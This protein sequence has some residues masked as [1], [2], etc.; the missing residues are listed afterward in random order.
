LTRVANHSDTGSVPIVANLNSSAS[1]LEAASLSTVE[2]FKG[3]P[4]SHLHALEERS[5]VH[6]FRAGHVFFRTG[7]TGQRLFLLEK[8][9]V[10]TF[11]ATGANKL[12]IAELKPPAIFG[13]MAFVGQCM[14]H[15][16]A[17]TTVASRIRIIGRAELDQVLDQYPVITRRLLD[18]VGER[19]L[20]VLL[21]L[22]ATSFRHLLPRI[23]SLLLERAQGESVEDLTHK[24]IAQ[25]LRVYRESVTAALGELRRA[26]IIAVDRKRIRV[27]DRSR[28]ERASRE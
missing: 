25:T 14:Y 5:E 7:E 12:V 2:L 24:E 9:R 6:D 4:T 20:R 15:C 11:R 3:L 28:L 26:G 13:E 21:D 16:S 1:L 10:E 17:Q 22:E 18:L 8:G 19:F 27:L 23:A